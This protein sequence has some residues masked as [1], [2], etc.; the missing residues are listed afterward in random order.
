LLSRRAWIIFTAVESSYYAQWHTSAEMEHIF[1]TAFGSRITFCGFQQVAPRRWVR[2]SCQG[3]KYLFQ[4]ATNNS[5]FSYSP[6][7]AISLDF[8]PR[9]FAGRV[10]IRPKP[11]DAA[12]HVS[13]KHDNWWSIDKRREGLSDRIGA[14]A[15]ESVPQITSWFDSLQSLPDVLSEIESRRSECINL[16]YG[17]YCYPV[18]AL[19]YAFLLARL[20]YESKTKSEFVRALKSPYFEP[21]LHQD[22]RNHFAS[23]LQYAK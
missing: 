23:E 15:A 19:S 11:K 12:V 17:F 8:L 5:G 9:I 18:L 21:D 4:L 16:E 1:S 22:L 13:F 2:D 20:G 7:G 6:C 10:K 14:I 3:F